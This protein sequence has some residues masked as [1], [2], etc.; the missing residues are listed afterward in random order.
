MF[1]TR[2]LYAAL[3][4]SVRYAFPAHLILL[5][6]TT[7]IKSGEEYRSLS[8][9]LRSLLHSPVASFLLGP[10]IFLSTQL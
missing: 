10:H 5:D 2:T 8:S 1:I 6:F 7:L 4:C 3:L 9:L